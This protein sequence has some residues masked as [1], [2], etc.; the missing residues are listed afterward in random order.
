MQLPFTLLSGICGLAHLWE[1]HVQYFMW[2]SP[3]GWWFYLACCKHINMFLWFFF[4]LKKLT[5]GHPLQSQSNVCPDHFQSRKIKGVLWFHISAA[6]ELV[7]C[8]VF[9]SFS[10]TEA[11]DFKQLQPAR[12]SLSVTQIHVQSQ[13]VFKPT[14]YTLNLEV[15][16]SCHLLSAL[17]LL[18]FILAKVFIIVKLSLHCLLKC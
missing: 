6:S 4:P 8:D 15:Q 12:E 9:S 13:K 18:I 17:I 14:T 5:Q 1:V 11:A 3:G 7:S 16:H 2:L 10:L